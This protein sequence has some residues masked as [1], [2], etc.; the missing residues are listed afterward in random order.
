MA[1]GWRQAGFDFTE[2]VVPTAQ[3]Q[4]VQIKSTFTGIQISAT[5]DGEPGLNS[6][7]AG[8]VPTAENQW[9]GNAWDGYANP[10]LDRLIAVFSTAL[11]ATQRTR[12][13]ADIAKFYSNEV[14]SISLYF[15]PA[16]W[17][18]SSDVTCPQFRPGENNVTWNVHVWELH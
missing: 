5:A 2:Y 13:A 10:Q 15:P 3:A 17:V 9:R 14:P 7:G 6:M 11:D 16:P 12:A 1:S 8:N 4:D 18:F